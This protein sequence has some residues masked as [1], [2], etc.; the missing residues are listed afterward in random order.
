MPTSYT[1]SS[2]RLVATQNIVPDIPD[3]DIRADEDI[4][5]EHNNP[6]AQHFEQMIEQKQKEHRAN[7]IEKTQRAI[8]GENTDTQ[9]P[10]KDYW[11]LNE[12]DQPEKPQNGYATFGSRIVVPGTDETGTAPTPSAEELEVERRLKEQPVAPEPEVAYPSYIKV[13]EPPGQQGLVEDIA[14]ANLTNPA[15]PPSAVQSTAV[16]DPTPPPIPPPILAPTPPPPPVTQPVNP[17][18]LNLASN[19]D[20]NVA[21][22][23]R[24]ADNNVKQLEDSNDEVIISLH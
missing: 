18:I 6:T 11:F 22:I 4:L 10:P 21:S 14:R 3:V 23:A 19:N 24:E 16:P 2:D 8:K 15:T 17:V 12:T 20:R 7:L 9:A 1:E 13:I 5:D